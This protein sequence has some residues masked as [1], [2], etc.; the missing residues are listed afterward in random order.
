MARKTKQELLE[1]FAVLVGDDDRDEITAFMEDLDDSYNDDRDE[2]LERIRAELETERERYNKDMADLQKRYD[3]DLA[4][5]KRQYRERFYRRD[6]PT[7][8]TE[9]KEIK[10]ETKG[11][12]DPADITYED[13]F[14]EEK[15][16]K[17]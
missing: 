6:N 2:E 16:D 14:T 7:E 13:I 8:E 12:K 5:A 11:E 9:V 3:D 15:E 17:N 4:A 10:T 1:A